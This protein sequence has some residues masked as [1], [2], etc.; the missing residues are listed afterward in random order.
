MESNID[1]KNVEMRTNEPVSME[2]I[3][4]AI[5]CILDDISQIQS[6]IDFLVQHLGLGAVGIKPVTLKEAAVF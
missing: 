6:K 5:G 3:P 1:K 4:L 2:N